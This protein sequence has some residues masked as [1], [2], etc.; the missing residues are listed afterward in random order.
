MA[1]V[2]HEP[3]ATE[4]TGSLLDFRH[5]ITVDEYHH[6]LDSGVFGPE[7]RVELLEG[8]VV[9]KMT[10]NPPHNLACDLIQHLLSSLMPNGYYLSMGTSMTIEEREG[11]PEPDALV[12]RGKP[13]DYKDRKRTAADSALIIEVSDTSYTY[14]RHQKAIVYAAVG[15]PVY[16]ILDLNRN[17]L[18]ILTKPV[19]QEQGSYYS[20]TTIYGLDDEIPLILDGKEITRFAAREVLP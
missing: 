5:R 16:W 3:P 10:K 9:D 1:T 7:P 17:R 6:M 13:R 19:K 15:V 12:L 11:E 14:D 8:V 18:E 4:T 20:H 2:T